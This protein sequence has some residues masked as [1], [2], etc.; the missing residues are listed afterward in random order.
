M[1]PRREEASPVGAQKDQGSNSLPQGSHSHGQRT[2]QPIVRGLGYY[3]LQRIHRA[4]S[5]DSN[6]THLHR[7]LKYLSLSAMLTTYTKRRIRAPCRRSI[8]KPMVRL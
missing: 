6:L 5:L 8:P 1:Y 4:G 7:L 2:T 3:Y